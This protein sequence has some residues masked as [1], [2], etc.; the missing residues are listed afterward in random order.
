MLD[1]SE[2][3]RICLTDEKAAN[4]C[5]Q[6][7][8]RESTLPLTPKKVGDKKEKLKQ[9]EKQ[10][11]VL[12]PRLNSTLK[13]SELDTATRNLKPKKVQGHSRH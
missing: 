2:V 13:I 12:S 11:N 4:E 8:R 9:E 6:L 10:E 3:C 5:V 1:V 7:Y